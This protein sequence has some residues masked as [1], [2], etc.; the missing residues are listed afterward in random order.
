MNRIGLIGT[1]L[2]ASIS[3]AAC[4]SYG[5]RNPEL[6]GAGVG[7]AIGAAAGAGVGA[8]V[9][10]VSPVEGAIAG[11][12][13]GAVIGAVTADGRQWYRDDRGNCFYVRDGRRIYDYDQ[14]C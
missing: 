3:L 10:G 5:D 12:V 11:A 7:A 4:E 13:A 9:G 8:V 2:A 14:R 1:M 6:R